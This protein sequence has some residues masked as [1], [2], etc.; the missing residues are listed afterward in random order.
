MKSSTLPA[1]VGPQQLAQAMQS[2][3]A[4]RLLDVRTA[5]E[6]GWS[7]IEGSYHIPLD[8]LSAHAPEISRVRAPVVL[9]CR[10][11]ARARTAENVLRREGMTDVHVLAGGVLAWRA[12]GLPVRRDPRSPADVLRR[13]MGFLGIVLAAFYFRQNAVLAL[14][15]GFVGFRMMSGQSAMPCAVAGTCA[16][17][18][19]D[20]SSTVRAMVEGPPAP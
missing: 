16:L 12:H 18:G 3:P 14:I 2:N 7:R 4:I 5:T 19:S 15:L 17:P 1:A 13:V 20:T 9:V 8:E 10:S 11:G 6:F